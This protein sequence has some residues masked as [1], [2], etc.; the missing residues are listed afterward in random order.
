MRKKKRGIVILAG[1]ISP[2]ELVAHIPIMCENNGVAYIYVKTK[3]DLAKASLSKRATTIFM[4][5]RPSSSH[6]LK[7]EY[8]SLHSLIMEVNPYMEANS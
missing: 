2:I 7:N 6:E 8:A 1:D 4:L 5:M 3:D